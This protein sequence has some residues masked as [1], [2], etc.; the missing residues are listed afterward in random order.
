M[1]SVFMTIRE[2]GPQYSA[3]VAFTKNND[4]VGTL[5][6]NASVQSLKIQILPGAVVCRYHFFYAHRFAAPSK[7]PAID[8][9]AISE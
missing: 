4:E 6:A 2:I 5:A 9:V 1:S 7:P 3:E 8:T